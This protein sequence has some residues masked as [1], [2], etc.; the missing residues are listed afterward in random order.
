MTRQF[1]SC[2]F[3]QL[4]C[5][6]VCPKR[7]IQG[8]SSITCNSKNWKQLKWPS[9][10]ELINKLWY[11]HKMKYPTR[12]KMKGMQLFTKNMNEPHFWI[13]EVRHKLDRQVETYYISFHFPLQKVQ[14]Q[15]NQSVVLEDKGEVTFGEEGKAVIAQ[16]MR[17]AFRELAKFYSLTWSVNIGICSVVFHSYC[18]FYVLC[19]SLF[20]CYTSEK[21]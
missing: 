17:T 13:K 4:R 19:T 21:N 12:M 3:N 15:M 18:I 14:K 6:H 2:I 10:G 9:K 20:L 5:L 7:Y 16:S 11:I 8:F 1:H